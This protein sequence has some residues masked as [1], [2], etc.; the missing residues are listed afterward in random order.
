MNY[1]VVLVISNCPK[2]SALNVIAGETSSN[3]MNARKELTFGLIHRYSQNN[4]WRESAWE[5]WLSFLHSRHRHKVLQHPDRLLPGWEHRKLISKHSEQCGRRSGLLRC[6]WCKFCTVSD[7]E[8]CYRP[9]A[10]KL[11]NF[12]VNSLR[13][14]LYKSKALLESLKTF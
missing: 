10:L 4:E 13:E 1:P 8:W 3:L 7:R 12:R 11:L 14:L 6:Q 9:K 5:R 2:T